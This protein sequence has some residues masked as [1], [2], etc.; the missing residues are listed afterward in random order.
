MDIASWLAAAVGLAAAGFVAAGLA[1]TAGL[2]AVGFAGA[3]A[4][5]AALL[6]GA[7][8]MTLWHFGHLTPLPAIVSGT[9]KAT[10]HWQFTRNGIR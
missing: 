5:A 10:P 9:F 4:A 6:E 7:T 2:E 1:A 3:V 8:A